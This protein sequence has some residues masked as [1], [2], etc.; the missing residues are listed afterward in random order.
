MLPSSKASGATAEFSISVEDWPKIE[1][2]YGHDLS[3]DVRQQIT[4]A[5]NRF[6][7]F[8]AFE[9]NA[10][11]L[12]PAI[13]MILRIRAASNKLQHEF[14]N[15]GGLAGM[16]A[17]RII[18]EHFYSETRVG[19]QKY[20]HAFP[21]LNVHTSEMLF[22]AIGDGL[23]SLSTACTQA[24]Q[25]MGDTNCK[26]DRPFQEGERWRLW[27]RQLTRIASENGLP[28]AVSKGSDKSRSNQVSPFVRLV[29]ALQ[30]RLPKEA[31]RHGH[32]MH[33]LATAIFRAR[34]EKKLESKSDS[35]GVSRVRNSAA[36][37]KK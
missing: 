33:G 32:G 6:L 2:P 14:V 9:R 3:A 22:E 31:R 26:D 16:H 10:E 35:R 20:E 17:Q 11:P 28:F 23:F 29:K 4:E 12:K 7:Y 25:T 21:G 19:V 27:I 8:E 13:D 34:G 1:K 5:T 36:R 30:E 18:S 24:L 37:S 15:C